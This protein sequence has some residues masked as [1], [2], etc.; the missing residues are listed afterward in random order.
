MSAARLIFAAVV[1][2]HLIAAAFAAPPEGIGGDEINQPQDFPGYCLRDWRGETSCYE[3]SREAWPAP[4]PAASIAEIL[5]PQAAPGANAGWRHVCGGVVVAPDWVLT[6]AHCVDKNAAKNGFGVRFGFA[7]RG[8]SEGVIRPIIAVVPHPNYRREKNNIAL[9]QFAEDQTVHIANPAN[10]PGDN[11]NLAYPRSRAT[12][13]PPPGEPDIAFTDISDRTG[14]F[15]GNSVLYRWNRIAGGSPEISATPLFQALSP[16]CN[17]QLAR[18]EFKFDDTGFCALSHDRPLCPTDNGSP[19]MGGSGDEMLVVAITN[20][21]RDSCA[22]SGEPG[23]FT[24]TGPYRPWL[25][26]VLKES[27]DRRKRESTTADDTPPEQ[28]PDL[29]IRQPQSLDR[30]P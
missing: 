25:R 26:S 8:S 13:F 17:L 28:T 12:R 20:W 27:Y 15:N 11:G 1:S 29:T 6:A 18:R 21:N 2:T 14:I 4:P 30:N 16:L 7:G 5:A 24:L 9:V 10:S 23:R 22:Q 19:V 3:G